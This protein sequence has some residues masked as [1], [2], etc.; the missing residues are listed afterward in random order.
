MLTE[1]AVVS[2]YSL[3]KPTDRK[4]RVDPDLENFFGFVIIDTHNIRRLTQLLRAI[5]TR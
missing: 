2:R 1:D 3:L 5:H 4:H